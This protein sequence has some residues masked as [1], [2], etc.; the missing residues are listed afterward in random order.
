[1]LRT[2]FQ[3]VDRLLVKFPDHL[4]RCA[5]DKA[6]IGNFLALGH[7]RTSPYQ[8]IPT[9]LGTVEDGRPHPDQAVVTNL[10]SVQ[11]RLVTNGAPCPNCQGESYI[12]MQNTVFL[13]VGPCP[14][15]DE[16]VVSAQRGPEPD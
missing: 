14:H 16:L 8:A 5:H 9:Y 15:A 7:Q 4:T 13:N 3:G 11:H 10:A 2:Q 1:M 6:A 12:G